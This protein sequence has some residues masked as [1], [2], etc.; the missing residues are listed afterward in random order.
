MS[1]TIV[2]YFLVF[3]LILGFIFYKIEGFIKTKILAIAM[4]FY[5]SSAV[6]FSFD[7]YMGWPAKDVSV[8]DKMVLMGILIFDKTTRNDGQIFVMGIPCSAATSANEC[9]SPNSDTS[10]LTMLSPI[11]I[12]GYVPE[13]LN[14]PR[15]FSFPYTEENRKAFGEARENIDGGGTSMFYKNG[16]PAGDQK[17]E[18]GQDGTGNG[19]GE[20]QAG[21]GTKNAESEG[22]KNIYIDNRNLKDIIRKDSQQ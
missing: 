21:E 10:I 12:F 9:L 18:T 13:K 17:D 5:I 1:L 7:S 14:T 6:Y 15:L 22:A 3:S 20:G 11:K 19:D 4:M 2:V 8:P 16:K